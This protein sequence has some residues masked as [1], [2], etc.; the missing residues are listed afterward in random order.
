MLPVADFYG[1]LT[2]AATEYMKM[3]AVFSEV[4]PGGI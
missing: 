2:M 4:L 1:T 3:Y